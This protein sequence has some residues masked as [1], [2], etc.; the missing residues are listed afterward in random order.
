MKPVSEPTPLTKEQKLKY[1]ITETVAEMTDGYCNLEKYKFDGDEYDYLEPVEKVVDE[2]VAQAILNERD[3]I[4]EI[5]NKM[6]S[7][8][9]GGQ[10]YMKGFVEGKEDERK[11]IWKAMALE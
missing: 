10:D 5:I 11:R 8:G 3:R 7:F 2:L 4:V 6:I 9:N 1:A